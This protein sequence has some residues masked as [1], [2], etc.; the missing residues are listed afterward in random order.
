MCSEILVNEE[1]TIQ[2]NISSD[3]IWCWKL[4]RSQVLS[5]GAAGVETTKSQSP[6]K[7]LAIQIF[8]SKVSGSTGVVVTGGEV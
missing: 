3:K 7:T 5:A 2:P 8:K 4:K 1:E 6:R